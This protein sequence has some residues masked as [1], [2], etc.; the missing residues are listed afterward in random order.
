MKLQGTHTFDAPRERVWRAILDPAILAR[1]LPGCEKLE[2][3]GENNYLG[4]LNV[5]VGPVKGQFQGTLV[6][7]DVRPLEGYHMKLDGKG[8]AGFM[9]GE[10]D[11]RLTDAGGSTT[12]TYDIDSQVGGRVAAVGQRLLESSSKSVARQGLEG[13]AREISAMGESEAAAA[14]VPPPAQ[15]SQTELAARVA[16]DVARDMAR[17]FVPPE[18]RP[19]LIGGALLAVA[20][21]GL[22]LARACSS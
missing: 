16:G 13:L 19:W 21:I 20:V 3:V 2:R 7:T 5:Q 12:L 14:P 4:V 22:L 6:L 10:G 1:T 15:L 11:L 18:R 9:N 17:D 8:P